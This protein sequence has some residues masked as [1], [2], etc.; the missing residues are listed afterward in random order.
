MKEQKKYEMIKKLCEVGENKQR[1]AIT[2]GVSIRTMNRLIAQYKAKGKQSFSHKNKG[3]K[4]KTTIDETIKSR[5][6]ELYNHDFYET[7]LVHFSELLKE[8]HQISISAETIRLW[9]LKLNIPSIKAHRKTRRQVVQKLKV[10]KVQ[11]STT[12]QKNEI[13]NLI[14]QV[15][16]PNLHPRRERSAYMGELIQMDASKHE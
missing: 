15:D 11:A 8:H 3:R 7:N 13:D 14:K 9:L 1:A 2:L 5:I 16:Y 4:P 12:K 10:K 6:L